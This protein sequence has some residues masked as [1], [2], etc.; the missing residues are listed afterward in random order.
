MRE[1]LQSLVKSNGEVRA[2]KFKYVAAFRENFKIEEK[3][4][5]FVER[6]MQ[7]ASQKEINSVKKHLY[8]QI[9]SEIKAEMRAQ[10]KEI[11]ERRG[12]KYSDSQLG[13]IIKNEQV[14]SRL[15]NRMEPNIQGKI[16]DRAMASSLARDG[17]TEA[18]R[19]HYQSEV[20]QN[21]E[22]SLESAHLRLQACLA[23]VQEEISSSANTPLKVCEVA[24]ALKKEEQAV[25]ASLHPDTASSY[26]QHIMDEFR[27][28][29]GDL[30][31][32][33]AVVLTVH[34]S[35]IVQ[36]IK[37]LEAKISSA[38]KEDM[39]EVKALGLDCGSAVRIP[40]TLYQL[41]V[42][43]DIGKYPKMAENME[44]I[45]QFTKD[46]DIPWF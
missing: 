42:I 40:S 10:V 14:A 46:Y 44:R 5:A 22:D 13:K 16:S 4:D 35:G 8:K 2:D 23:K 15:A 9:D 45:R 11:K 33:A 19:E 18:I 34:I 17:K 27:N 7:G 41:G 37:K 25:L 1:G 26:K 39:Q 28:M 38:G 31:Q 21:I 24:S 12:E 20:K 32:H 36:D 6:T 29:R 30:A 3:V 43:L